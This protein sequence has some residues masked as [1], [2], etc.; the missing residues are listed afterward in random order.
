MSG[1]RDSG[2]IRP[3]R[4]PVGRLALFF[5][6]LGGPLA[7]TVHLLAS[8]PL[9]PLACDMGTNAPLNVITAGTAL[10]SAAAG[11]V[12]WWAH[13]RLRGAGEDPL[14]DGAPGAGSGDAEPGA[15]WAGGD[16]PFAWARFMAVCGA[17]LGAFF[18]FVILVEGLPPILQD[19]CLENL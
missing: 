1:V 9:V 8:Y 5:A 12:G 15:L 10:V 18:V 7:W 6:L 11:A 19:A 14:D 13:R 17:L 3:D 2:D 16:P 4:P